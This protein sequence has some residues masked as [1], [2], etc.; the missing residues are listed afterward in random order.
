MWVY[1]GNVKKYEYS[2]EKALDLLAEA[3]FQKGPDGI[4]RKDGKPFEFNILLSQGNRCGHRALRLSR[5]D[6]RR[7]VFT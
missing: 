2:K 4:L 3:G 6:F 1:N 7:S 5:G